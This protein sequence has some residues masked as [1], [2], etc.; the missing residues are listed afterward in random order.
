VEEKNFK[1]PNPIAKV[2]RPAIKKNKIKRILDKKV[3]AERSILNKSKDDNIDTILTHIENQR[4]FDNYNFANF[5]IS[6]WKE[7][8]NPKKTELPIDNGI[9]Q[10]K[11]ENDSDKYENK[12][13]ILSEFEKLEKNIILETQN[14][15]FVSVSPEPNRSKFMVKYND[16]IYY[17]E[18]YVLEYFKFKK[19]ISTYS[20]IVN[21]NQFENIFANVS[22]LDNKLKDAILNLSQTE[23]NFLSKHTIGMPDL[24]VYDKIHK[25]YY[26]VEV[27]SQNDKLSIT[28][29][30]W[31]NEFM[32]LNSN[33]GYILFKVNN[34]GNKNP[35]SK[36]T[37]IKGIQYRGVTLDYVNS[38]AVGDKLILKHEK[39]NK[40]D[41]TAIQIFH[42]KTLLGY[43]PRNLDKKEQLLSAINNNNYVCSVISKNPYSDLYGYRIY[44]EIN[45]F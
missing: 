45:Y 21:Q 30:Y 42:K 18:E 7:Y 22:K 15:E 3:K 10:I 39:Q 4:D 40:V 11:Y 44:I 32:K 35:T 9:V 20:V 43:V 27:K 24:F 1:K 12:E 29:K 34:T 41:P 37:L 17:L 28:Q 8:I 26:F 6:D 5:G 33:V 36:I 16:K 13:Q 38:I 31:F 19:Y 14:V 2:K 25:K 23:I